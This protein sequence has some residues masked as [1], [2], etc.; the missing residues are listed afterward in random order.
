M[1]TSTGSADLSSDVQ[2]PPLQNGEHLSRQEFELRYEAMPHIKKAEL[3][4]GIV[5]LAS[6]LRFKS[7]AKPH[8][9]LIVCWAHIQ[10]RLW[11]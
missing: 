5:H 11:V 9:L 4:E 2:I 10:W 1:N 6:P 8:G 7:H 3:I